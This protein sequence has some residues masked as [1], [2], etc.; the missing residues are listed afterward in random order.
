MQ[1]KFLLNYH[2]YFNIYAITNFLLNALNWCKFIFSQLE[3]TLEYYSGENK[4]TT[5]FLNTTL[6]NNI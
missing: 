5:E 2:I 6:F 1:E 3:F 4:S